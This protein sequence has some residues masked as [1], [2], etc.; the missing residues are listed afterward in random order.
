MTHPFDHDV[1]LHVQIEIL[2]LPITGVLKLVQFH[3]LVALQNFDHLKGMELLFVI[4]AHHIWDLVRK[5]LLQ[6]T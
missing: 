2:L 5:S 1:A 6:L 3:Y 4:R